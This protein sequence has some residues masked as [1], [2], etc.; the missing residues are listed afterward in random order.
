MPVRAG[1]GAGIVIEHLAGR[2]MQ[3]KQPALSKLRIAHHQPV[4]C[5]V[6]ELEIERFADAHAGAGE[7]AE[8]SAVHPWLQRGRRSGLR[9][10]VHQGSNLLRREDKWRSPSWPVLT[11]RARRG[12]LMSSVLRVQVAGQVDESA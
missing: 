4:S 8:Q 7:Q 9:S 2:R 3:D 6:V 1:L 10:F 11:E 5:H 12:Y